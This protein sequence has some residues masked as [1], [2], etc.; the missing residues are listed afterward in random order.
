MYKNSDNY[1]MF[2]KHLR[3]LRMD[4]YMITSMITTLNITPRE[5]VMNICEASLIYAKPLIVHIPF[6]KR[7]KGT[8]K[9]T[10]SLL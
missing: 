2:K 10:C 8:I 9:M 4:N 6:M 5:I 3:A 1:Y 7:F